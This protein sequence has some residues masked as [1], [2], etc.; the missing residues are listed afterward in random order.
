MDYRVW[1]LSTE[2]AT[3]AEEGPSQGDGRFPW[4]PSLRQLLPSL[5]SP[6]R[7]LCFSWCFLLCFVWLSAGLLSI[8]LQDK[9]SFQQGP[10]YRLRASPPLLC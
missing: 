8:G 10:Q 9:H 2:E 1:L 6:A 3:G 4:G 5:P 7:L